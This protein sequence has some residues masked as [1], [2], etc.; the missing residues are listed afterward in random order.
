LRPSD[1]SVEEGGE[2]LSDF[3]GRFEWENQ[4]REPRAPL[5]GVQKAHALTLQW[6]A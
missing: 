1:W 4:S 6:A 3:I 2:D 5:I